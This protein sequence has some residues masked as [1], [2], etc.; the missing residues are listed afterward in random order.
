MMSLLKKTMIKELIQSISN[1][2]AK[3]RLCRKIRKKKIDINNLNG[4][5]LSRT[6]LSD[7]DIR[8]AKLSFSCLIKTKLKNTILQ[9]A[10][11]KHAY[12][13][14]A[15]LSGASLVYVNFSGADLSGAKF[16]GANLCNADF[17][18]ADLTNANLTDVKIDRT[19][20]FTGAIMINVIVDA[21]RLNIAITTGADIQPL[22]I[23]GQVLYSLS[24]KLYNT[25]KIVPI[26][27]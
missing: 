21:Q 26:T 15:D 17:T 5:D 9:G 4:V 8:G 14:G 3:Q 18:G 22:D 20:N 23:F 12:L 16:N 27:C 25:K 2:I 13:Q 1:Y 7:I 10:V 6:N 11:I 24:F 19:T